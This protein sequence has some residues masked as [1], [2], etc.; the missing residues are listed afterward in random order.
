MDKDGNP[1]AIGRALLNGLDPE[2]ADCRAESSE[3]TLSNG[4]TVYVALDGGYY[5]KCTFEYLGHETVERR[6]DKQFELERAIVYEE[7]C[8]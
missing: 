6:K 7:G 1:T 3:V 8:P 4:A 2:L 5:D